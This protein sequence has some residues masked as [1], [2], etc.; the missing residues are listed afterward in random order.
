MA[1]LLFLYD[2]LVLIYFILPSACFFQGDGRS[3]SDESI[4]ADG[5]RLSTRL[6]CFLADGLRHSTRFACIL[7][8]SLLPSA[9]LDWILADSLRP[10][11]SL[12]WI[13]ADG[14]LRSHMI[15]H[16][17]TDHFACK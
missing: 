1:D 10:S 17:P 9:S 8:D 15:H 16:I 3:R 12:G 6:A 2:R 7:A 5:L 11:A 4:L 13:L 14:V